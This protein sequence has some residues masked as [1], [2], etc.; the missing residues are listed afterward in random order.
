MVAPQGALKVIVVQKCLAGVPSAN[1]SCHKGQPGSVSK[2]DSVHREHKQNHAKLLQKKRGFIFK[3]SPLLRLYLYFVPR[4]QIS[5]PKLLS[6]RGETQLTETQVSSQQ[7][8]PVCTRQAL[9]RRMTTTCLLKPTAYPSL[10]MTSRLSTMMI[11]TTWSTNLHMASTI[12]LTTHTHHPSVTLMLPQDL[13]RIFLTSRN[14][15][16]PIIAILS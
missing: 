6:C 3:V 5:R 14:F 1:H 2:C 13:Q 4:L 15:K 12:Q 9:I 11:L 7:A 8:T 16:R 10:R